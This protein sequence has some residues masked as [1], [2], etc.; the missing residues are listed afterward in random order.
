MRLQRAPRDSFLCFGIAG[1]FQAHFEAENQHKTREARMSEDS[2]PR[3]VFVSFRRT[4]SGEVSINGA[5]T[6]QHM[7]PDADVFAVSILPEHVSKR[8]LVSLSMALREPA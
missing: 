1:S 7:L 5:P 6:S 4:P 2:K 8:V 3:V